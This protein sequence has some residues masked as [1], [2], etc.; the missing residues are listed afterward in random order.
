MEELLQNK[1]IDVAELQ[2][3]IHKENTAEIIEE[4]KK[5]K[6]EMNKIAESKKLL[7][8]DNNQ[9]RKF[10]ATLPT[11]EEWDGMNQELISLKKIV[12]NISQSQLHTVPMKLQSTAPDKIHPSYEEELTILENVNCCILIIYSRLED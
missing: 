8:N 1:D 12:N 4:N 7:E 11:H 3:M 9:L 5:H 2:K 10:L 6:K